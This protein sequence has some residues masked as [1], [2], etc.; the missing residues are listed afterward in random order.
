MMQGWSVMDR[1]GEI[2]VPTLVIAGR[3]DFLFPPESQALLAAGIPA[4]AAPDHRTGR[5]QPP[6]RAAGRDAGGR[7]GLPRRGAVPRGD[8]GRR[9]TASC[10]RRRREPDHGRRREST[11]ATQ[12]RIR[13]IYVH[14]SGSP[15]ARQRSCSSTAAGRA[16]RCGASIMDRPGERRFTAWRQISPASGAATGSRR[17][18]C[19]RRQTS[20]RSSSLPASRAPRARRRPV[21]RR[22]GGARAAR[23]PPGGP[24]PRGDRRSVRPSGTGRSD[25][26]G[27][28]HPRLAD[29]Q[30]TPCGRG[31]APDR[32]GATWDLPC[33]RRPRPRSDA[34][35]WRAIRLRSRGPCST[36]PARPCSWPASES[37]PGHRTP[38][39][40][41]SC[42]MRPPLSCHGSATPGSCGGAICTSAWS[43]GWLAGE[44][45]PA[46]LV[47]EPPSPSA[48]GRVLSLLPGPQPDAYDRPGWQPR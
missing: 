22:V 38:R 7:R 1:L 25:H 31:L 2:R 41:R 14:E 10:R 6:V 26:P 39:S 35:G 4:R 42:R 34:H 32:T 13:D 23:P 19:A 48:V 44:A 5:P 18:R 24:R 20:S 36:L 3:D 11:P 15:A 47:P 27:R 17:S 16:E 43:K 9:T 21:V 12:R 33:A 45:L 29:R 28:S 8:G 37:T 46:G 40:P 30:H